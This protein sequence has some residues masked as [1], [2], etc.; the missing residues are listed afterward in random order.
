MQD[1]DD[2]DVLPGDALVVDDVRAVG[3][4][5]VALQDVIA[6]TSHLRILGQRVKDPVDVLQICIA[7]PDSPP[8]FGVACNRLEI[9]Q[10]GPGEAEAH[11][12]S[13]SSSETSD[14]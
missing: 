3:K 8:G 1:A 9:G 13:P 2:Q 5:S 4:S 11:G 12:R 6:C 14:S 10:G 7:L